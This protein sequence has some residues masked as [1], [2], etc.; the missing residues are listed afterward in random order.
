[1]SEKRFKVNYEK[2]TEN[3]YLPCGL[4]DMGENSHIYK[5]EDV[6]DLLNKQQATISKL[7]EEK[8]YWKSKA[9]TLLMQVRR[10]T[11]RMSDK[12]V[13]EFG[14]ELEDE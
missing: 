10:L 11:P 13:I 5:I 12:E 8:G 6:C 2:F 7:E 14:K 9:M 4:I 1:M 3:E